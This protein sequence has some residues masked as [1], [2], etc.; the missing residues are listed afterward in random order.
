MEFSIILVLFTISIG[1]MIMTRWKIGIIEK[2][3]EK[4]SSTQH[5]FL[6]QCKNKFVQNYDLN[7]DMLNINIFVDK[8]LTKTKICG[9]KLDMWNHISGQAFFWS[10]LCCGI[11]IFKGIYEDVQLRELIPFYAIAIAEVYLYFSF[12]SIFDSSKC[13]R[14]MRLN[15]ME[16]FEHHKKNRLHVVEDFQKEEEELQKQIENKIDEKLPSYFTTEKEKELESLL[17]EFLL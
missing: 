3:T 10:V 6:K 16:Y 12:A 8:Y 17:Q 7:K 14:Q 5:Y 1:T 15:M 4:M 11:F 9:C 13:M 2:E